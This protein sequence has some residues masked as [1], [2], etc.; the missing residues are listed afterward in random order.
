MTQ[1]ATKNLYQIAISLILVAA[2]AACANNEAQIEVEPVLPET[3]LYTKAMDKLA[4]GNYVPAISDLETLEARY[5]Y[6]RYSAQVQL[7]LI[8]AYYR[9][10]QSIAAQQAAARFIR[11]HPDHEHVDYAYYLKGLTAFEENKGT[12]DNYLAS[13]KAK[14]DPGAMRDSFNDFNTLVQRFPHS[15]YAADAK[16]RM[17]YLRNLL[18]QHEI[19]VAA[20]YM[21]R[22]AWLA[23]A[24]RAQ[25]VLENYQL[26]PSV[27]PALEILVTAYTE[28][29]LTDNAN[30]AQRVLEENF[31]AATQ[32]SATPE[33]A[34]ASWFDKLTFGVFAEDSEP[35]E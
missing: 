34:P 2:L 7:E 31:A 15:Q 28:L 27:K 1:A 32:P 3:E 21:S 24:N 20:Y 10:K 19:H 33:S 17:V 6:G 9:S 16:A 22:S 26:T 18:A 30:N 4:A 5:P 14:K 35:A 25:Y 11:L 29:G 8:Y 23:A 13:E 12:L